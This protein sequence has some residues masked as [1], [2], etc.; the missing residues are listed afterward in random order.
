[1]PATTFGP[2]SNYI[3]LLLD[4]VCVVDV[5]NKFVFVS[6][7]CERIFGYTQTEML[8]RKVT[9]L[10]HPDDLQATIEKANEVI[11]GKQLPYFT[12]RYI[13]KDGS[14]VHIMWSAR[15]SESDQLRIAVARD[16]SS[17]VRSEIRQRA[18]FAISEAAQEFL[19]LPALFARIN[20]IVCEL[21]KV[22]QFHIVLYDGHEQ[23]PPPLQWLIKSVAACP[24]KLLLV[25]EDRDQQTSCWAG[26]QLRSSNTLL[27]VML[28]CRQGDNLSFSADDQN[29]LQFVSAQ[30][31]TAVERKQMLAKLQQMA[32]Y[33]YLTGLP[34]RALFND[35]VHS[36]LIRAKREKTNIC[37]LFIDLDRFKEINDQFGH[38]IGDL[39]L[40][41]VARRLE[42]CV[43]ECDT[44]ARLGGDEFVVLL[45]NIGN[46]INVEQIIQKI[47]HS[48]KHSI[49]LESHATRITLSIGAAHYPDHAQDIDGLLRYADQQMYKMK[50]RSER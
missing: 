33:D 12:N 15:W 14:I 11:G 13:R 10:V 42:A 45:E 40:V 38:A 5:H 37:L 43:R 19:E 6:A 39:L 28:V 35:R 46:E 49:Q 30:I 26:L 7:S 50:N 22:D 25:E 47:H 9:D 18:T 27:G 48:L 23:H 16:I 32:L 41:Q 36:A 8:G 31:T 21:L 4:T 17:T 1:M 24:D 34:N 3:D 20:T 29:L 44:V 2:L